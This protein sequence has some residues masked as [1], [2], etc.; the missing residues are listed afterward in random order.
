MVSKKN[1][2]RYWRGL[3]KYLL[4][5]AFVAITLIFIFDFYLFDKA[6]IVNEANKIGKIF[7]NLLFSFVAAYIFYLLT[8]YTKEYNNR[9]AMIPSLKYFLKQIIGDT[10]RIMQTMSKATGVTITENSSPED[11][12]CVCNLIN[13]LTIPPKLNEY[14]RLEIAGNW[15]NNLF[16]HKR[17]VEEAISRIRSQYFVVIDDELIELLGEIENCS[18]FQ[19]VNFTIQL[20]LGNTDMS[21]FNKDFI[22]YFALT[23]KLKEYINNL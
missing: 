10:E 11:I 16:F 2:H 5:A 21:C 19:N 4:M 9:K 15:F 18:L 13:P 8:V 12:S 17:V 23:K 1:I 20:N 7:Y 6:P 22:D 14:N 3:N